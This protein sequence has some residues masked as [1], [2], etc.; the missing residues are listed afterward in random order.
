MACVL[1]CIGLARFIRPAPGEMTSSPPF[2][3]P[4]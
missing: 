3:E 2:V 1:A 4:A